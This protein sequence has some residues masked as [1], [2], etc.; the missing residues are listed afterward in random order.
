MTT[1]I[2]RV[3]TADQWPLAGY[4]TFKMYKGE[5][6]ICICCPACGHSATLGDHIVH[7]DGEV[8]PGIVCN[9]CTF[10][11]EIELEMFSPITNHGSKAIH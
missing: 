11:D 7:D 6:I 8:E 4:W 3:T 2:K 5:T 1:K 10:A 9:T